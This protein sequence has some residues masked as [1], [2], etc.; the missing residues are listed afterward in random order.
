MFFSD[1]SSLWRLLAV[2]VPAY[3]GLILLLSISGKRTLSKFNAFD[4]IVTVA[5]GSILSAGLLSKTLAL[6][7]VLGAFALLVGLQFVVTWSSIRWTGVDAL[8]KSEPRLLLH[9]GEFLPQA[10]KGERI[11]EGEVLAAIRS[12]GLASPARVESVVL[13]TDGTLSVVTEA[14]SSSPRALSDVR[15]HPVSAG[16]GESGSA[17][18]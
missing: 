15:G 6:S 16:P 14:G 12:S 7:D 10:L 9:R 3:F 8:V 4:L 13:E 17:R 5:F 11:T 18:R 2:G 1:W